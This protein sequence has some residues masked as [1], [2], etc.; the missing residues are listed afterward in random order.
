MLRLP[1]ISAAVVCTVLL[2]LVPAAAARGE[3]EHGSPALS[4]TFIVGGAM[5]AV[6]NATR[7]PADG[8]FVGGLAGVV[9]GTMGLIYCNQAENVRDETAIRIAC[10]TSLAA[11]AAALGRHIQVERRKKRPT[12]SLFLDMSGGRRGGV[13]YRF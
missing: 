8:S 5:L 1:R 7:I 3:E 2:V 12:V 4:A 9:I 11:G 10:G 6:S 13:E